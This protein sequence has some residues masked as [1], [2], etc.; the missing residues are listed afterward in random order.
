[1]LPPP[2]PASELAPP[3]L[4]VLPHTPSLARRDVLSWAIALRGSQSPALSVRGLS[5]S[6]TRGV[7]DEIGGVVEGD[8]G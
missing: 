2:S 1:M 7:H 8:V 3:P 6:Q 4:E 5:G